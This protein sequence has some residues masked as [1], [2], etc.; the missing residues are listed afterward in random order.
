MLLP[1][2]EEQRQWE[3]FGVS[4]ELVL[5]KSHCYQQFFTLTMLLL[6]HF[7]RVRLFM[8]PGTVALQVPLSMGFSRHEYWSGLRCPPSGDRPNRGVEPAS[9]VSCIGRQ[10]LQ[11]HLG[12]ESFLAI[13][14]L[15]VLKHQDLCLLFFLIKGTIFLPPTPLFLVSLY[16]FKTGKGLRTP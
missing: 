10:V 6:G 7:S 12:R 9:H 2:T 8:T 14:L 16:I 1:P 3:I 15:L 5:F 13:S 11:C 4:S